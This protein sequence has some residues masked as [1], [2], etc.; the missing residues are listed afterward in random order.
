M[1]SS[2]SSA[3]P[4]VSNF[5]TI[6]LDRNNYP[7]WRAQFLPLL[8][9]HNLLSY[10]T[11]ETQCPSAFLLDDNGK[12]TDKVNPLYNEWIQ[13]DEMILSWITSS[14]TPKQKS[15]FEEFMLHRKMMKCYLLSL[16]LLHWR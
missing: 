16:S 15:H 2:S 4:S 5:L 1:A 10:V 6:K 9:S 7:L 8:R 14:L 11:G 12:F 13:T 3:A